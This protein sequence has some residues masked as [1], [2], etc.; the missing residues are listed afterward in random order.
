MTDH[1]TAPLPPSSDRPW[2]VVAFWFS[3]ATLVAATGSSSTYD[4]KDLPTI[5]ATCFVLLGIFAVGL[6]IALGVSGLLRWG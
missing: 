2:W 1:E 6:L 4:R 3:L 5:R